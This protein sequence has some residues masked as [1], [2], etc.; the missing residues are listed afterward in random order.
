MASELKA[1]HID[2]DLAPV[3]DVDSNPRN[4]VI[5]T[6]NKLE[7]LF[8]YRKL[9]IGIA[10]HFFLFLSLSLSCT[11]PAGDRSYSSDSEKV[12]KLG[13]AFIEAMQAEGVATCAKHFPGHGDTLQVRKR[14][15]SLS[16]EE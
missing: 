3:V 5:G 6:V 9:I 13:S 7:K 12:G 2:M 4:P 10:F 1:V 14:I 8:P 15:A 11:M 16:P